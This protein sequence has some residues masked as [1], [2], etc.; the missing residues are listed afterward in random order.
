MRI[1]FLL[2]LITIPV[3]LY[4]VK[5]SIK[6][7][8]K[9]SEVAGA[10][11]S[12]ELLSP[13]SPVE[14]TPKENL[15]GKAV[16]D[17][18]V[19]TK[20]SY[21]VAILNLKNNGIYLSNEHRKYKTGSLY[22]LW[23]MAVAFEQ[24]RD[25]KLHESDIVSRD[26]DELYRKFNIASVSAEANAPTKTPEQID[27][28][29]ITFTVGQALEQM[30]IVSDNDAALLLSEKVGLTNVASFL[31]KNGFSE[32]KLG[33]RDGYPTT[34]AL[35]IALFLKKLYK[36]ELTD[37]VYTD[38]MLAL[39]KRQR[40]NSKLPKYLPDELV[41]AH[42]TGEL[43]EFTHDAGIVYAPTGDYIIVLLSE[44]DNRLQAEERISNIS[45]AVY[46]YF[47][48]ATSPYLK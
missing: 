18:L 36:G 30:I 16:K 33:T 19:G 4:I 24:I 41:I 38:K 21:G 9:T 31:T 44:S 37:K 8:P 6:E 48:Q 7:Q 3:L 13:L 40:L 27:Q 26:R 22:K 10:T 12:R 47:T 2:L 35:D 20:G 25:G 14:P 34:T 46:E 29:K 45:K 11:T 42:K 5:L 43:D 1:R 23:I 39:L 15:L 17:A 28:D 32:S